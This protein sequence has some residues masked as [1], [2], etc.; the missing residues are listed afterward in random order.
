MYGKGSHNWDPWIGFRKA[1]A[2]LQSSEILKLQRSKKHKRF[3]FIALRHVYTRRWIPNSYCWFFFSFLH[4][5]SFCAKNPLCALGNCRDQVCIVKVGATV[6]RKQLQQ[7]GSCHRTAF[8]SKQNYP[9]HLFIFTALP[10]RHGQLRGN[11]LLWWSCRLPPGQGWKRGRRCCGESFLSA[12]MNSTLST[13][14]RRGFFDLW[15]C[16]VITEENKKVFIKR[17]FVTF[18]ICFHLPRREE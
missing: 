1:T 13:L 10:L 18:Q 3:S 4:K 15:Q 8:S 16:T 14:P 9:C 17:L 5:L 6:R 7:P 11:E 12:L 2:K